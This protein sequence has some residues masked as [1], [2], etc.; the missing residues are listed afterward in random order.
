MATE[1]TQAD[2]WDVRVQGGNVYL[3]DVVNDVVDEASIANAGATLHVA[4]GQCYLDYSGHTGIYDGDGGLATAANLNDPTG[5]FV[6]GTGDIF[7]A[8]SDNNRV[9]EVTSNGDIKT[10]AGPTGTVKPFGL[11][12]DPSGTIYISDFEGYCVKELSGTTLTTFAGVCSTSSSAHG[13]NVTPTGIPVSQVLFGATRPRAVH[14][15]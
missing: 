4:A 14:P 9:R 5:L 11:T 8:D 6:D 13:D 3:S 15:R 7:I 1:G 10:I 12:E 2:P